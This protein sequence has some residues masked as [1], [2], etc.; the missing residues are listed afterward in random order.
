VSEPLDIVEVLRRPLETI[1]QCRR[2]LYVRAEIAAAE[3]DRLREERRW[4]P[5]GERLPE[6]NEANHFQFTCLVYSDAGVFEMT[7]EINTYA[8]HE[9]HRQPRWKWR[10]MISLWEITHWMPLPPGPETQE[11]PCV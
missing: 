1:S 9:R 6:L 2:M 5:M 4:I 7:Y 8:K 3:I 11:V 10:G